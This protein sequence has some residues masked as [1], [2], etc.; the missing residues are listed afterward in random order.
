MHTRVFL[1]RLHRVPLKPFSKL[2]ANPSTQRFSPGWIE[3]IEKNVYLDYKPYPNRPHNDPHSKSYVPSELDEYHE[4]T[5][6]QAYNDIITHLK[7]D[8]KMQKK[9]YETLETID[10]PYLNG[11]PGVHKNVYPDG[12]KNYSPPEKLGFQNVKEMEYPELDAIS[13]NQDRWLDQSIFYPKYEK[14]THYDVDWQKE[15]DTRPVTTDY[16]HDKGYKYDVPVPISEKWPHVADRMGYPEILGDPWERLLRLEGDIYHP[17]YLDQPF[18]QIPS[19]DPNPSLNFEEGEVIYENTQLLEWGKFFTLTGLSM[20]GFLGAFIPYSLFYKTHLF[21]S[22]AMEN[23]FQSYH[24]FSMF[25]FDNLGLHIPIFAGAGGYLLYAGLVTY[26]FL[27]IF[28][29]LNF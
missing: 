17:N 11:I 26:C 10:R 25:Y 21:M 27:F 15:L 9:I 8:I 28:E 18:I 1:Q 2:P 12:V 23:I 4:K 5:Q 24:N 14:M 22:S 13:R 7:N 6:T 29:Y 3:N 20:F 19:S 16:H